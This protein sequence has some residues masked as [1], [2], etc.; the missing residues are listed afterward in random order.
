M[1]R[2]EVAVMFRIMTATYPN[3]YKKDEQL[4]D[5]ISVWNVIFAADDA[6][7]VES[8]MYT[9]INENHEFAPAPG[10][11]RA[12][13]QKIL[14][15]DELSEGDAW[16]MVRRAIGNGLYG[17]QE[18][19]DKLPE[20]VKK[21]VGS[22]QWIHAIAM[23][24]NANMSVESSNFYKRYRKVMEDKKERACMPP[25]VQKLIEELTDKTSEN[26]VAILEDKRAVSAHEYEERRQKA[27]DDFLKT[28]EQPLSE[29]T[30]TSIE[31]LKE[32]LGYGRLDN[33]D[34]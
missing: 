2:E 31:M 8:A 6:K 20:D 34:A 12:I 15:P 33:Q 18:E 9:Y 29:K 11:I 5:A 22:P 7:L 10:Q 21:A 1:T 26:E 25:A 4:M 14:N 3:T 24:E 30:I 23:D 16:N 19:F 17:A 13:M 32:R 27:I 28:E